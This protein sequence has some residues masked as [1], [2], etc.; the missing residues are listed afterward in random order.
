MD[1]LSSEEQPLQMKRWPK[2]TIAAGY[3][4]TVALHSDGTVIAVGDDK[5]GQCQVSS[6]QD[7]TAV[8]A[9]TGHIGNSHTVGLQKNGKV[10]AVGWNKYQQCDV[11][12]WLDIKAIA[13]AW[14]EHSD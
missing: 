4:H 8:A 3:R 10:V 12:D 11:N 1:R 7:I 2:K 9:G 6:W 14:R 5:Y 13:A